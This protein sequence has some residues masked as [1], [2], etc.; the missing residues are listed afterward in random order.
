M[1]FLDTETCGL[2]G[3]AVLLQYAEDDGEI[4]LHSLWKET[5]GETLQ[6]FEYIANQDVCGFNLAF[7]WFHIA[8]LFSMFSILADRHGY[9][10][11]PEDYIDEL[12]EIEPEARLYDFTIKPKRALDLMLTARK[13]KYQSLMA[14]KDIRI[15]RV[16]AQ[17]AF[18][19][20]RELE[21]RIAING[22]Y[23]SRR[24]DAYAPNW[25]V[26]EIEDQ[27]A[28]KDVVLRFAASGALKT[29]AEHALGVKS[30][31]ILKFVDIEV[32]KKYLPY[33]KGWAPFAK[34]FSSKQNGWR[35]RVKKKGSKETIAYTWPRF[36]Q[37][38]IDHWHY[39][40]MARKYGTDDVTYTRALYK[41]FE[42]PTPGD[43]DSELA[44]MVGCV[45]WRGFKINLEKLKKLKEKAITKLS[46]CP[47]SPKHVK[48]YIAETMD[49]IEGSLFKSTKKTVLED[50]AE[51]MKC[52]CVIYGD[53]EEAEILPGMSFDFGVKDEQPEVCPRCNGT[54]IH[55][56]AARAREVLD[57]RK[58]IK[59]IEMYDKL[60]KAGRF[61][62]SFR[63]IGTLSSRMSGAD[64]LNAQGI[65]H[66]KEIRD[67]FEL[68]DEGFELCGGDFDSFEV[69][70][71]DAAYDDPALRREITELRPCQKCEQKGWTYSKKPSE[72]AADNLGTDE[73]DG[74]IKYKCV[75]DE[76][77]GTLKAAYKIHGLFGMELSGLSYG[78]VLRSK[79]TN[80]DWYTI[81]KSGVFAMIYGGNWKT[82]VVKQ[83]IEEE[84]A[85]K[86]EDGFVHR[87]PGIAR[88][89][90]KI[91]DD[92]CSMRQPGGI[93]SKVVWKEPKEYIES[94]LGFRRY[95]TLEN[96][97]CGELFKLANKP[98]QGWKKMKQ[99]VKRKDRE[100]FVGGATSSA[101]YGAAFGIQAANM[102]AAANHVIQ[103]TGA[104][105]TKRVER[106]VWD[107]QPHGISRW[108]V[109]P[110]NV[111]DEIACPTRKGYGDEIQKTVNETVESFRPNVPLI[112]MDWCQGAS[113]WATMK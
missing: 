74:Q 99:K 93:G 96:Q 7:D 103:S 55:P 70:I 90:K 88:A 21:E 54:K 56:A 11:I 98:P 39:N 27:P 83:G 25:S 37:Q 85:K 62:A 45:R 50:M 95:F 59:E 12:A 92:F 77:N 48:A 89:R 49:A 33:E 36:V 67:C 110:M 82:L 2:H 60:L 8:K 43:D 13:G 108:R 63:V 32:P 18:A 44:C 53:K 75:C 101:L 61:H 52:D 105:I 57:A 10:A 22:I 104:T 40:D 102:R 47:T 100:Q 72:K 58:A 9:D 3:V 14:R 80:K 91:D 30:D 68:A 76:C 81:G 84:R 65:N 16:P 28:F 87:F 97:I 113:S 109:V 86:A 73:V 107:H 78:E 42:C 112:K 79:G 71:A 17:L 38:H 29:L 1:I 46:K 6:L 23:F 64:G 24:K 20:Q 51:K 69:V 111:H 41:F 94:L 66:K 19:L 5:V 26:Q 15:K 35:V 4:K 31:V 106:R 34:A